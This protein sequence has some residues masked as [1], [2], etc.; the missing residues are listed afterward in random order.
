MKN[1]S[2]D[3][4]EAKAEENAFDD[5][6]LW[7]KDEQGDDEADV[8][9]LKVGESIEGVL[10][11]KYD[12][13]KYGCGIYKIKVKNDDRLKIIL[14]TTLLDKMMGKREIHEMVKIERLP[15]Q[16]SGSGR[17]YQ[18]FEVYHPKVDS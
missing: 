11:D 7:E 17:T 18:V 16:K 9:K 8:I 12:S 15:D 6:I 1:Q 5:G 14:G 4:E 2:L 10:M 13:P 3:E